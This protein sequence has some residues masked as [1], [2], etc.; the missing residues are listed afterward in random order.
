[1]V[2]GVGTF[3]CRLC[4]AIRRDSKET[5]PVQE[6]LFLGFSEPSSCL[7]VMRFEDL[8][9]FFSCCF[10]W[11]ERSKEILTLCQVVVEPLAP[12]RNEECVSKEI[13]VVVSAGGAAPHKGG[14]TTPRGRQQFDNT[15]GYPGEDITIIRLL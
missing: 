15:R 7:I 6:R 13:F 1:M 11:V 14:R 8:V 12:G 5:L 4:C 3:L 10:L 2:R 9:V